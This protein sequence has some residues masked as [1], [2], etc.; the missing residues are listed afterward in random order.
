MNVQ[1]GDMAR[2]ISAEHGN[3]GRTCFVLFE[4]GELTADGWEWAVELLQPAF[5]WNGPE[6]K[7]T[8]EEAGHV[9]KCP[10]KKLRR[11]DPPSDPIESEEKHE[12][13]SLVDSPPG[14]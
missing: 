5:V 3:L 9:C 6:R 8:R 4:P 14:A 11:I 10:D 12:V 13:P 7:V 1:P 2:V